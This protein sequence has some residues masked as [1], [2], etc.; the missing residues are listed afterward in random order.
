[1]KMGYVALIGR[2]NAGK[3]TLLNHL[4]GQKLCITSRRPQTT[5]HRIH[6]IKTTPVGQ[7][8]FVDTPGIHTDQK[9]AMNRYLTKTASRVLAGVDVIVWV[10]DQ[11]RWHEENELVLGQ[12]RHLTCPVILAVNKIDQCE[13]KETLLPF[14]DDAAQR[15]GF[16]AIVPIAALKNLNLDR[17]EAT[18]MDLLPEGEPAYPEDQVTDR[19]ERFFA[20][21]II[22][23]KLIR[24]LGQEVPHAITVQI[25]QFKEEDN[26]LTRVHAIIWVEREGQKIIVIG[27][28]G[29]VLKKVGQ[30][31]REE[32]EKMFGR[33][34]FL[35]LWVKVKKGW[36]DNETALQS[37]GYSE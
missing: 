9:K 11:W 4:V 7:A 17:L 1:M 24:S 3:S 37:L 35:N 13:D 25:E 23:E 15:F 8:V 36:S 33:K 34:I 29:G 16:A 31:A 30:R 6:G 19:P 10:V 28:Q 18:I 20:A 22:R 27:K 21:E 5:R 2:P 12:L 14:L 32:M 26:G